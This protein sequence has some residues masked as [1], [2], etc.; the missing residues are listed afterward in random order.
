MF[1]F[2][3]DRPWPSGEPWSIDP[4]DG[5]LALGASPPSRSRSPRSPLA[6]ASASRALGVAGLAICIWALQ[7][8]M[9]IAGTHWGMREAIAHL[10]RAAHDLRREARLLRRAASSYDD[11][12]DR[13]RRPGRSRRSIPDTLQVGQPMTITVAAQQG[14]RRARSIEQDDRARRHG[15]PRS[16]ITTSRSRCPRRAREARAADRDAA[17]DRPARPAAGA[18]RRRRSADRVAAVLARRE[19]LVAA[20]RSGAGCPR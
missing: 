9:P 3:Y 7:V 8:Y 19:L 6:R 18:R 11:W 2:R 14:R 1:V 15:R 20:T 16:A 13:R 17:S 4:S 5:F 10:L 12:H